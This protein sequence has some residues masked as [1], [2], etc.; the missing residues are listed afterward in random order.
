MSYW[1]IWIDEN[2]N[3]LLG[4]SKDNETAQIAKFCSHTSEWTFYDLPESSGFPSVIYDLMVDSQSRLWFTGNI[5]LASVPYTPTTCLTSS[6]ETTFKSELCASVSFQ[7]GFINFHDCEKILNGN[8]QFDL[9]DSVGRLLDHREISAASIF[10][11]DLTAGV[12][13]VQL[14]D[15]KNLPQVIKMIIN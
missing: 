9:Y 6:T 1:G 7:Q 12:Y 5:G 11:D 8:L 15:E 14:I 2:D 13:Y 3:I 10:V 4:G